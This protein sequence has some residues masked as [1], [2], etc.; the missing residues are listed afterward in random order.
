MASPFI[1]L[2]QPR[3]FENAVQ[4]ARRKVDVNAGSGPV[5]AASLASRFSL[6]HLAEA[7]VSRETRGLL[8]PGTNGMRPR[9]DV[10]KN[11]GCGVPPNR[12]SQ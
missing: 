10:G 3:L 12:A 8:R 9:N 5:P 7:L 2:L 4:G 6:I 11:R 1:L